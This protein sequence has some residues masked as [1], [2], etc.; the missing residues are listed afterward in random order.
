[1]PMRVLIVDDEPIARRRISRLLKL[2]D[3]VEV[4][5][6][7][8]SGT[9]AVAAIKEQRPDLVFLDVQMP[10]LDG[11]G[12]VSAL[13]DPEQM[14]AIVFVTAYNEYAVK[15]FDVNAVDYVL[16]PFDGERFRSAFQRARTTL[17]QKNSAEAGRR[18][19][20]LLE[21]VLGEQ[22]AQA[23]TAA[24]TAN[25]ATPAPTVPRARYLDRLMV[26][27]DGRVFFV[28]VADVDWFEASGNYVRVHVGRVS[29]LI[30]ETMHGI[31][32]QLDPNLF[33]R[34][35][36]AVIV[37]MDR[38]RELQPWFAGDYIVILR[39]GRQLKLSR[40]YREALQSRMHRLA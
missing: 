25:G 6:E 2:E 3:D 39:D 38:I 13:G 5:N 18:I 19:K 12:V 31:E 16:K 26:K 35:H 33:A 37:N 28:K 21:E 40:T 11:F 32:A 10:D 20:A 8:G 15:A 30:R 14:P 36:R 7:V 4:V 17:E 9:D 22:R 27:H 29:H 24:G 1:M 34:I 23:L